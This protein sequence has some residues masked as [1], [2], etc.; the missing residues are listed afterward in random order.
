VERRWH[1]LSSSGR[2]RLQPSCVYLNGVSILFVVFRYG[3]TVTKSGTGLGTVTSS[4]AGV[5]RDAHGDPQ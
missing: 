4:P 3:L 1:G 5:D 2:D